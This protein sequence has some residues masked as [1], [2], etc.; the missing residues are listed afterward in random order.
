MKIL[1]ID[2]GIKN[3]SFCLISVVEVENN[4]NMNPETPSFCI[5]KWDIVD[6]TGQSASI[7]CTFVDPKTKKSCTSIAKFEKSTTDEH[8]H[9]HVY[10]CPKHVKK[11]P[12]V[13]YHKNF[14]LKKLN[15]CSV[16]DLSEKMRSFINPNY[17]SD[18]GIKLTKKQMV[19]K[20]VVYGESDTF[21]EIGVRVNAGTIDLVTIGRNIQS[22]FDAILAGISG[23]DK[24]LIENQIGPIANKMKTIQGMISQYFIMRDGNVDIEFIS[25]SNKL[26]GFDN[27]SE[28]PV[29]VLNLL[30]V[31]SKKSKKIGIPIDKDGGEALG[32]PLAECDDRDKDREHLTTEPCN[33]IVPL[34]NKKVNDKIEYTKRKK[35]GISIC[36]NLIKTNDRLVSWISFFE[37]HKKKDDLADCLLQGLWFIKNKLV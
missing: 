32:K 37:S 31:Q 27:C 10:L 8:E 1:S 19:E 30:V 33:V 25:S 20:L 18:K 7:P 24:I 3:L 14:C 13:Q 29:P 26:K 15:K 17:C 22:K 4:M 16:V 34:T 11:H 5:D 6:L 9:E 23:I 2:V 21:K 35:L 28:C 36:G 12:F